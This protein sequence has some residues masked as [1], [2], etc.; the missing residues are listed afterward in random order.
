MTQGIILSFNR[1]LVSAFES[2]V[3]REKERESVR[4]REDPFFHAEVFGGKPI[5]KRLSI[6]IISE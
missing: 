3:E 2:D 1:P 4:A 5:L 6:L